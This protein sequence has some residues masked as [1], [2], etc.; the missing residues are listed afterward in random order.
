VAIV[1]G[2]QNRR[3]PKQVAA[4]TMEGMRKRGRTRKRCRDEVEELNVT[5]IKN[6]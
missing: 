4:A 5:G 2:I 6:R 3:M 1:E